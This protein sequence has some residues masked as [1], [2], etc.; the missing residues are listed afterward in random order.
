[1]FGYHIAGKVI[2]NI[3]KVVIIIHNYSLEK[4]TSMPTIYLPVSSKTEV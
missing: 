2:T 4:L 3:V 1:M